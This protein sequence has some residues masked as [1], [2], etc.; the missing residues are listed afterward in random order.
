VAFGPRARGRSRPD[1]DREAQ[2]LLD[3]F[4]IGNLGHRRPR[5]LSGGQAQRVAIARALATRPRLLLLDEPF[6]GLD[7]AVQ[8]DL[9]QILDQLAHEGTAILVATHD[10]S[11]V[12]NS[13][14]EAICLNRRVIA[15]GPSADVLTA[16]VLTETFQRHLLAVPRQDSLRVVADG[17]GGRNERGLLGGG[18][19]G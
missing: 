4:G 1:A 12:A 11:C 8:H 7:A 18:E 15:Q 2:A 3:T 14:D 16:E 13:C 5:E 6:A 10:L 9:I 19:G 17:P